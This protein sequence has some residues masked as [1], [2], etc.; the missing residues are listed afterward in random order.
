[1]GTNKAL[2]SLN[3]TTLVEQ[4]KATVAQVCEKVFLLGSRQLYGS[5]GECYEDIYRD[6]GPLGGIH[7]AL[8]NSPSP[9]SLVTSVDTPFVSAEFLSYMVERAVNSSTVVTAPCIGGVVQPVCAV[10]SR[11]FLPLVEAALKSGKHKV[12]P[13]FPPHQTL[14]LTEAEVE[15]FA[16]SA[17]MFENLNTPE[18][19]ERARRRS[20]GQ[21]P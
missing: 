21:K 6:C 10:F 8:V 3:G 4:T 5:F 17:E 13:L 20:S 9:Y 15:Q 16:L 11:S 12:E 2:L 18:D 7:T 1:M 14:V 19:F